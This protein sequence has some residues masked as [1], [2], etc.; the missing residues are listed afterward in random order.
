MAARLKKMKAAAKRNELERKKNLHSKP[1]KTVKK[2]K[3]KKT[4][5]YTSNVHLNRVEE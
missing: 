2:K 3:K 1:H 5:H 4:G